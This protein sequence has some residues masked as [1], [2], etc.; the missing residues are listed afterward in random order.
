MRELSHLVS[1]SSVARA[2]LHGPRSP[3]PAA[4]GRMG[5]ALPRSILTTTANAAEFISSPPRARRSVSIA[6]K[7]DTKGESKQQTYYAPRASS[8]S[9]SRNRRASAAAATVAASASFLPSAAA[10]APRVLQLPTASRA[11]LASLRTFLHS[12]PRVGLRVRRETADADVDAS[13]RGGTHNHHSHSDSDDDSDGVDAS[14]W[15]HPGDRVHRRGESLES[16][17][18]TGSSVLDSPTGRHSLSMHIPAAAVRASSAHSPPPP[19]HKEEE[20]RRSLHA[21]QLLH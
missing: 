21:S 2:H 10:P 9:P 17:S 7:P 14:M 3:S 19:P 20:H 5:G 13:P 18:S 16:I 12:P 4:S 11:T 1:S 8:R 15:A 6:D